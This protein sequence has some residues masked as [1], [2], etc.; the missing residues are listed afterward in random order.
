M[1]CFVV[2]FSGRGRGSCPLQ[3]WVI[4]FQWKGEGILPPP[5]L[6]HIFHDVKV[7]CLH[8]RQRRTSHGHEN[9][10][11][12][13]H[14]H[15]SSTGR[16]VTCP[17]HCRTAHPAWPAR[18][19]LMAPRLSAAGTWHNTL[20]THLSATGTRHN[21][22]QT[23]LSAAGTW[24]IANTH[25]SAA[26]TWHN[27]SQTHTYQL[28]EPDTPQ[29]HACQLQEPHTSQTISI[30]CRNL[31][32]HI[33]NNLSRAVLGRHQQDG[34]MPNVDLTLIVSIIVHKKKKKEKKES[35]SNKQTLGNVFTYTHAH[36]HTQAHHT[37]DV[38][39]TPLKSITTA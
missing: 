26:G 37:H 6:S 3:N 5:K 7:S 19:G 33:T 13:L 22:L 16:P 35:T 2:V 24:H 8:Q 15:H 20:Q 11:R 39:L 18:W 10:H 31:T 1:R 25:L 38:H 32:Q 23:H 34:D 14:S 4:F 29:T 28:Q 12:M 27:T 17:P 9:P 30:S 36:K 21:T